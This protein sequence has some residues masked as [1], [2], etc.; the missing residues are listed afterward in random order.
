MT[1]RS[2][3]VLVVMAAIAAGCGDERPASGDGRAV[4][5]AELAGEIGSISGDDALAD[6]LFVTVG[7]ASRVYV[8]QWRV[9]YVAVFDS[10]GSLLGAIGR[11][12]MG[13]GEF[14][15]QPGRMGWKGD[16]LWVSGGYKTQLFSRSGEYLRGVGFRNPVPGQE[17]LTYTPGHPASDGTFVTSTGYPLDLVQEGILTEGP[18]LRVDATGAVV[19]TLAWIALAGRAMALHIREGT[20]SYTSSH[21]FRSEPIWHA[22]SDGTE[23]FI[24]E[25]RPSSGAGIN[26]FRILRISVAGDTLVDRRVPYQPVEVGPDAR[27]R[28]VRDMARRYADLYS[29]TEAAAAAAVRESAEFPD[30]W[31]PVSDFVLSRDGH[32]WLRREA[33]SPDSV[34]WQV[35][36]GTA[37][38]VAEAW[39]PTDLEVHY[40]D[41]SQIWGEVTDSLDVPYLRRYVLQP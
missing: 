24:V 40:V 18:I 14:S 19:D 20:T 35:L 37:R 36:D 3:L 13:P 25:R 29:M 10:T 28:V 1:L 9:P 30:H 27:D 17:A 32:L 33:T 4:W 26:T 8:T 21:P 41:E 31:P 16:T 23:I 6:V 22:T 7:P 11:A 34:R 39:L 2:A 12:G 15:P 5:T 38:P